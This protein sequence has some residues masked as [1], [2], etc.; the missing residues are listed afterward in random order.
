M[1]RH[2]ILTTITRIFFSLFLII[3]FFPI[4]TATVIGPNTTCELTHFNVSFYKNFT[5]DNLYCITADNVMIFE[6]SSMYQG[7]FT[8]SLVS[9]ALPVNI[10][11]YGVDNNMYVNFSAL[12]TSAG[13]GVNFSIGLYQSGDTVTLNHDTIE[14]ALLSPL[15]ANSTGYVNFAWTFDGSE[16]FE[17]ELG[18]SLISITYQHD[19]EIEGIESLGSLPG[20]VVLILVLV[21]LLGAIVQA[22]EGKQPLIVLV[23]GFIFL[24][25]VLSTTF[26]PLET[27]AASLTGQLGGVVTETL[28][29]TNATGGLSAFVSNPPV[30]LGSETVYSDG[31][32]LGA[33]D[34]SINYVSGL[35]IVS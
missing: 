25:Y 1:N 17:L 35:V 12:N 19:S 13:T 10:T 31:I 4:A 33:G 34:Y 20:V 30:L 5:V 26:A 32:A 7:N 14:D 22:S 8:I 23:F 24:F 15:T 27:S 3:F 21:I 2:T 28:G 11:L 9:N 29:T 16:N 18:G 6:N